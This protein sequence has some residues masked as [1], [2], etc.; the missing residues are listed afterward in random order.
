MAGEMNLKIYYK[1]KHSNEHIKFCTSDAEGDLIILL[2]HLIMLNILQ[3]PNGVFCI[4]V[5]NF[6]KLDSCLQAGP[7]PGQ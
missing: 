1:L 3:N 6:N 2:I 5:A 7:R 4:L